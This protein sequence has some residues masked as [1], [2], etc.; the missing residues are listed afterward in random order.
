MKL[1]PSFTTVTPLSKTITM[2]VF[3]ILPVLGFFYGVRYQQKLDAPLITP[4]TPAQTI[5]KIVY[6]PLTSTNNWK[7]YTNAKIGM[8]FK[9]PPS[10]SLITKHT[11]SNREVDNPKEINTAVLSGKE[12]ELVLIWGPMGY[13]GGCDSWKEITIDGKDQQICSSPFENNTEMWSPITNGS[14]DYEKANGMRAIVKPPL[15]SNRPIIL[16]IFSTIHYF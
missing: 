11:F 5:E 10:W 8:T 14:R 15:E 12:G 4:S 3:V 13:G 6:Q 16:T 7:T 1:P 9:Y 2:I